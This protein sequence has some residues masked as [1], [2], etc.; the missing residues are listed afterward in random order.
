M[1]KGEHSSKNL[2]SQLYK[3]VTSWLIIHRIVLRINCFLSTI[4]CFLPLSLEIKVS[5][6]KQVRRNVSCT[7]YFG[8]VGHIEARH[9]PHYSLTASQPNSMVRIT[10]TLKCF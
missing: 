8:I 6:H 9:L 2:I 5:V 3:E 4:S 1:K 10:D 7:T